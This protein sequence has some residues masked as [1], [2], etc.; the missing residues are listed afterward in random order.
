MLISGT[1]CWKDKFNCMRNVYYILMNKIIVMQ[2][3]L[4]LTSTI[5]RPVKATGSRVTVRS[6]VSINARATA[7]ATVKGQL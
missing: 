4:I 2:Q 1:F 3:T 5:M 6:T 7:R